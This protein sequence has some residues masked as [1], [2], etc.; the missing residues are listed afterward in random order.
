MFFRFAGVVVFTDVVL[1][2]R[3]SKCNQTNGYLECLSGEC[4]LASKKCDGFNDC[5]DLTDEASC[6]YIMFSHK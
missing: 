5:A 3:I 1:P 6:K 4:Y 2:Q